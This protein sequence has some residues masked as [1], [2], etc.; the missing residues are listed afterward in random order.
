MDHPQDYKVLGSLARRPPDSR[1]EEEWGTFH[2]RFHSRINGSSKT[3]R[4]QCNCLLGKDVQAADLYD[5]ETNRMF[6]GTNDDLRR[7]ECSFC[8]RSADH[9]NLII[10]EALEEC[11]AR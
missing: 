2:S 9:M 8:C 7:L 10:A 11:D 6:L 4:S 1:E 3:K 5:K